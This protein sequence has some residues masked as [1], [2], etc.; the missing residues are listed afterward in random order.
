MQPAQYFLR[1]NVQMEPLFNQWYAWSHLISPATAAMNIANSHLKLMKSY[2]AAPQIHASALKNPAMMGGPFIDYQGGR[3]AEI[4]QLMERTLKE[5]AHMVELAASI[6]ALDD[7][8]RGEA[9][10]HSMEPLYAKVPESLKGFVELVYDLNDNPSI[11]FFE[12]LLYKSR[13]YDPSLQSLALSLIHHDDRAFALSTPRLPADGILHLRLP[14]GH[15]GVDELFRMRDVPQSFEYIRERLGLAPEQERLFSTFLTTEG[16]PRRPRYDG[17]GVRVRYYGHACTSVETRDVFVLTDPVISYAYD[18]GISRYTHLDLPDVIDYVVITHAHQDHIMFESLLQLRHKVGT[19]VVPRSGN[20]ALQD[21]SLKLVLE[22]IGFKRVVEIGEMETVE[23]EGGSITGLPFL[24]EHSD[25]NV[26]TKLAHF[27]RLRGRSFLFAADTNNIEPK[28]YEHVFRHL[29]DIDVLFLG[30]E[31]DGAPLSWL[32]GPLLTRTLDR[33]M[34]QS[35]RLDGSNYEKGIALVNQ[36]NCKEVYVYAMGQEPWLN[37]VMS[38]KYADDSNPI[39]ASNRLVADCQG[40]GIVAERLFGQ[41]E[42][43]Y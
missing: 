18:N 43:V 15:E 37:Y 3:V 29:G 8:L 31:C 35:R 42:R 20:G 33:K 5:Q 30:M 21:P 26:A 7:L 23:I 38:I 40:R 14:F 32:Y 22:N 11:R 34:D 12:G 6:K 24:G 39:V 25:L 9:R 13:Y 2:V 1:Q 27:V 19:V 4:R 17:D 10:G 41:K 16:Q 36:F 28:L